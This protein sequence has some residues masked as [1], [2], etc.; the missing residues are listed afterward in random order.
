MTSDLDRLLHRARRTR[1][2]QPSYDVEAGRRRIAEK[3][4]ARRTPQ[5]LPPPRL[6]AC[7]CAPGE[8]P[9]AAAPV[10]DS[11]GLTF[12]DY[13]ERDLRLLATHVIN[14]DQAPD[15][16]DNLMEP[17]R[18]RIEP[19]G[20]LV[21]ACLLHL[22][23]QPREAQ[24]WWQ[25]A[26]GAGNGTAAY[27]LYFHHARLGELRDAEHWFDQAARLE[28]SPSEAIVPTPPTVPEYARNTAW[29]VQYLTDTHLQRPDPALRE[30]IDSRPT[31]RD[32]MCGAFRLPTDD[33]ADH[34]HDLVA[35]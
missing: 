26:A 21:F 12:H 27:C 20:G 32:E 17:D 13:A 30:A 14:N 7:P 9:L 2:D 10:T 33:I 34:L 3:L 31:L 24:W 4:A 19:R 22:T 5:Q 6:P 16:L 15:W 11:Q 23:G 25:F 8:T 35:N 29:F 18:D 1:A 28:S